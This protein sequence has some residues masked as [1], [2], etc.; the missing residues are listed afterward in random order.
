MERELWKVLYRLAKQLDKA[1]GKWL[2]SAAD[3]LITYFWA[4]VHDRPQ[5]W[6]T[7][8]ENWPADLL[9]ARLPP[10]STL[11]RRMRTPETVELLLRIEQDLLQLLLTDD[12]WVRIIDAKPLVVSGVSKDPDV[13]Y[14]HAAGSWQKGYK[15]HAIWGAGPMP[16][17]WGLAPMNASEKTMARHL[18]GSSPGSGYLLG[19]AQFDVGYL[20]DSSAEVGYQ[21]VVKK[22]SHRGR[23]G[24]GHRRQSPFRLRSIE[25]LK[26]AFGKALYRYRRAIERKFSALTTFGGGLGPLPAW[27]RRLPRVRNWVHAKLLIVGVRWLL[28]HKPTALAVA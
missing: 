11:S 3:I 22:T 15:L 13:G 1:W 26:T 5:N 8:S 4:V 20:Y 19:D 23:G 16:V 2:Y 27:V 21:L 28:R 17:A 24:L 25:L 12:E 7:D 6:A 10:Q 14:G 9:P 18:I